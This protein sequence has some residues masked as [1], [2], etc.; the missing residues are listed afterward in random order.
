MGFEQMSRTESRACT[1]PELLRWTSDFLVLANK[2][3][4]MIACAHGLDC[5]PDL[6]RNAQQEL[7]AWAAYLEDHP[8]IAAELELASVAD[9]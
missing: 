2:A 5:P 9:D 4:C 3:I 7:R 1:P 8:S 6:H